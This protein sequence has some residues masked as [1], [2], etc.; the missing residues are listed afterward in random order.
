MENQSVASYELFKQANVGFGAYVRTT[1]N[2]NGTFN[3]S[4]GHSFIILSYDKEGITYLEGNA[5]GYGL[6]CVT[7]RTWDEFNANQLGSRNRKICHIVQHNEITYCPHESFGNLGDCVS[8]RHPYDWESTFDPTCAG[9]YRATENDAAEAN[10]EVGEGSLVEV[11][12]SCVNAAGNAW[13]RVALGG[14]YGYVPVSMLEYETSAPLR[15]SC[16]GF[17][18]SSQAVLEKNLSL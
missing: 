14:E 1:T 12:G 5:N 11:L 16:D 17:S 15:V 3:G 2:R 4:G 7:R 10:F 6:V 18:P 13:Y 8:C 9:R